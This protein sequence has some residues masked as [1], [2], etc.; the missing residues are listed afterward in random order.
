MKDLGKW[1]LPFILVCATS[2]TTMNSFVDDGYY[3]ATYRQKDMADAAAAKAAAAAAR[4]EAAAAKA[5]AEAAKLEAQ[6]Q[7]STTT[8][9][10]QPDYTTTENQ[11]GT[12]VI[13][14]YYFDMDDYY[15]YAYSAR[16]RRFY[17]PAYYGWSYYDP[18]FTNGYWYSRY[19]GDWG[20]SIY[21]GYSFWWDS[22]YYRPYH[23][24][25]HYVHHGFYWGY[26]D[27]HYYY[28]PYHPYYGFGHGYNSGYR[29]GYRDGYRA[30]KYGSYHHNNYADH[31][32]NNY[33][34][35]RSFGYAH[36][37]SIQGN[38][39]GTSGGGSSLRN[40]PAVAST[41]GFSQSPST[42]FG[43]RYQASVRNASIHSSSAQQG[44]SQAVSTSTSVSNSNQVNSAAVSQKPETNNRVA[45][46][47]TSVRNANDPANSSST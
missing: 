18:W 17:S 31:Y 46:R 3:N 23:Y 8:E 43:E 25:P 15:D 22:W 39:A 42:N 41:G 10:R 12:T 40:N 13:N 19:P 20:I 44:G 47:P 5:E 7:Y 14:N 34:N 26:Y 30:G 32:Y 16:L 4:A 36:R 37:N 29:Q 28:H 1:A 33:D 11:G 45:E 6:R 24:H 21:L 2:C 9:N 27:P 38:S 35:N